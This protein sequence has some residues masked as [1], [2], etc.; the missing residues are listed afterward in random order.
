MLISHQSSTRNH[1]LQ[2]QWRKQQWLAKNATWEELK[3][4]LEY[5]NGAIKTLVYQ[6]LIDRHDG[7]DFHIIDQVFSDTLYYTRVGDGHGGSTGFIGTYLI[8]T[9]YHLDINVPGPPPQFVKDINLS[10]EE[11]EIIL[12]KYKDLKEIE[13]RRRYRHR[14]EK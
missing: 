8:E 11:L 10:K 7:S 2:Q 3:E 6:A 5:P 13:N 9:A 12:Q 14:K 1:R 4:L